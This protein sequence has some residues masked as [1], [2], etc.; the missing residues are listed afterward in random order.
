MSAVDLLVAAA[1][2]VRGVLFN[3]DWEELNKISRGLAGEGVI[4]HCIMD[5][6]FFLFW[7][8]TKVWV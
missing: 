7:S 4:G 5:R 2:C 8:F 6:V 1:G 3:E